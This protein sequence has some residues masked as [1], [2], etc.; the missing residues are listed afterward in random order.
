MKLVL[1]I[2]ISKLFQAWF[3]KER[4]KWYPVMIAQNI[5]REGM[6]VNIR[7]KTA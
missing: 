1:I 5:E 4:A 3:E 6:K 2:L 7:G